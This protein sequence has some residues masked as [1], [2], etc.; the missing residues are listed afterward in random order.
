MAAPE[1]VRP[2]LDAIEEAV[3]GVIEA[4]NDARY[5]RRTDEPHSG[6]RVGEAL[7]RVEEATTHWFAVADELEGALDDVL[8]R[9]P[10]NESEVRAC[11]SALMLLHTAVMNEVAL[12]QPLELVDGDQRL[13][14]TPDWPAAEDAVLEEV[15]FGRGD[16]VALL[17]IGTDDDPGP[18]PPGTVASNQEVGQAVLYGSADAVKAV[19]AGA[20]AAPLVGAVPLPAGVSDPIREL[21]ERFGE[22][23]LDEA[24]DDLPGR[25]SKLVRLA[26]KRV[27]RLLGK[28]LHGYRD[29]V[30]DASDQL[31]SDGARDE[32]AHR[33]V[34]AQLMSRLYDTGDVLDRGTAAIDAAHGLEL[35]ARVR[36]LR[37][38]EKSNGRWVG[39]VKLLSPGLGK[40]WAVP[41]PLGPVLL[42]AAPAAA[43]ALLAW[44]V[45]VSGDQLDTRRHFPN[46]WKGVVR[47]SEGE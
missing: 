41:I 4:V 35:R 10:E 7:A 22:W 6:L 23:A 40:L 45:L 31:L 15:A 24:I 43:A 8:E 11:Q 13:A 26:L 1:E 39:P 29:D 25:V 30:I 9:R 17:Y 20:S 19:I 38:L 33:T 2:Q 46:F 34:V 27:K 21:L 28:I 12:V 47:R 14:D 16:L 32:S 36:R 18:E 5:D 37:K 44:V 3:R 42:P